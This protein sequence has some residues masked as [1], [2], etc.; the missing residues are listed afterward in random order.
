ML[1]PVHYLLR[2]DTNWQLIVYFTRFAKDDYDDEPASETLVKPAAPSTSVY[3]RPRA[4]PK[5]RRPV[6]LSEQDRFAYKASSVQPIV[7]NSFSL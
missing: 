3:A 4:P 7:G 5:I 1:I 2:I 6:P